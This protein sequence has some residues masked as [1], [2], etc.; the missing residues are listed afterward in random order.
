MSYQLPESARPLRGLCAQRFLFSA[1]PEKYHQ[2]IADLDARMVATIGGLFKDGCQ[3]LIPTA[4]GPVA[5]S[6][7]APFVP[8]SDLREYL[9]VLS[10]V[11]PDPG[12]QP[13]EKLLENFEAVTVLLGKKATGK[14]TI[15]EILAQN[16]DFSSMATSD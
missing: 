13:N 15:G 9:E 12:L 3:D 2:Q 10:A 7:L 6:S 4:A 1:N 16:Y 14:G 11:E 5:L 8:Q